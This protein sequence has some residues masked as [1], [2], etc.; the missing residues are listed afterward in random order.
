[1]SPR[2]QARRLQALQQLAGAQQ[3]AELARLSGI[4]A[5]L[6]DAESAREALGAA[7]ARE[8][9]FATEA[10]E[11]PVFHA[12]DMHLVLT[13]RAKGALEGHI[14][15]LVAEREAARRTAARAFGKATILNQLRDRLTAANRPKG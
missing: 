12:L 8:V 6:R 13:E 11:M 1:M 7:V 14:A 4:A 5:R 3:D 15:V 2:D 9:D 10:S